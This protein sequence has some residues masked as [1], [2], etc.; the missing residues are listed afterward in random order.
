MKF[1]HT[2]D[3][4][5]DSKIESLPSEKSKIRREEILRSFERLA[6]YA[7]ENGVRAVIIAGDM[8]DSPRVSIKTRNRVLHAIA[9]NSKVDFLYLSGNH[10]SDNFIDLLED[11]PQNLK[12][13]G[14]EWT[15]FRYGNV[16]ISGIKLVG[17]NFKIV[18]DTLNLSPND[19]NIVTLHAQAYFYEKTAENVSIP[20]LKDKSVDYLA[21]GHVHA[22]SDGEIDNRGRYAYSGAL[23]G[24]GFDELGDKGFILIDTEENKLT[25]NFVK[26]SSR[27][28]YDYEFSVEGKTNWYQARQELIKELTEKFSPDSIV[29]VVLTGDRNLDLDI[30]KDNLALRLNE[31]FFYAKAYDK[32]QI[33][34]DVNDYALDKSVRGEFIRTVWESDLSDEMKGKIITC[35]FNALKGEEI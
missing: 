19:V 18:C 31:L 20:A 26:F 23:D 4:H 16:V 7:T 15:A 32:T 13:F 3:L 21:L 35:G 28:F 2:A 6:D 5:L 9:S 17:A 24:R 22:R 14:E 29:K 1:I 8:F 11:C 30:D 10:D 25:T 34:I 27:V 12:I 33:K